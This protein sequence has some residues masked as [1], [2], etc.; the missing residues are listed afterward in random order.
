MDHRGLHAGGCHPS[1][2]PPIKEECLVTVPCYKP[3][4]GFLVLL[5]TGLSTQNKALSPSFH[6][7]HLCRHTSG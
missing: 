1:T 6:L 5:Q 7:F 3:A 4:G 2:K